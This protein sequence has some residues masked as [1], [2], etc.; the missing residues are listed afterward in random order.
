MKSQ[1][2][3]TSALLAGD[4]S[5]FI[6]PTLPTNSIPSKNERCWSTRGLVGAIMSTF[7]PFERTSAATRRATAVLPSPVGRITR[8]LSLRQ[9]LAMLA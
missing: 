8:V 6:S 1:E 3:M 4:M 2:A 5:P 7:L 9:D